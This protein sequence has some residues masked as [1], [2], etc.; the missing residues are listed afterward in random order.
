MY[1]AKEFAAAGGLMSYARRAF[2]ISWRAGRFV[3]RVLQAAKANDIPVEQP[4]K[5]EFVINPMAAMALG[6]TIPPSLLLWADRVI[7]P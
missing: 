5:F 4:T 6:L 3:D 1:G 7:D 2:R